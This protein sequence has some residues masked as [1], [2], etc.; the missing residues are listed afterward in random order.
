MW[1]AFHKDLADL[2]SDD[3]IARQST[4]LSCVVVNGGQTSYDPRFIHKLF[5]T[6][7]VHPALITL[8]G[9]KGPDDLGDPQLIKKF[10]DSS[11]INHLTKDDPPVLLYYSQAN[12]PLP[13][14]S[15]GGQHI[16]HP[17]FGF[18]FK[19]KADALGVTC[20]VK[21]RED[22]QDPGQSSAAV[23]RD[24]VQFFLKHLG[25]D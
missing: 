3:P 7:K 8:F 20:V 11:V 13:K 1:L 22:Y 25:V 17:K 12:R 23:V 9:M 16:H 5:D 6:D 15:N 24:Q 21:L 4:R 14:N 18:V 19:K 10:E 2:Q